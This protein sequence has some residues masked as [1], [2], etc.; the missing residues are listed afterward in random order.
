MRTLNENDR[1][2]ITDSGLFDAVWYSKRFADVA[3]VGLDPLEHYF[4]IGIYAGRDPGPLF[5]GKHYL[6][7]LNGRRHADVPVLDYLRQ[8]WQEQI[9]P[10]P[11]FDVGFYLDRNEDIRAA[12]LDPLRH[13]RYAGGLEGRQPHP[14]FPTWRVLERCP[15]LREAHRNPLEYYLSGDWTEDPCPE[16]TAYLALQESR[17]GPRL[18]TSRAPQPTPAHIPREKLPSAGLVSTDL[19]AIAIYLPQFHAIPENDEWWGK[20]FTEWTNVRRA[21]PQYEGHHQPHVPH[22]NLGYYDLHDASVLEKQAAMARAA[23]IE[24]FCFYY[25]W[26]NGRRLLN[27]PTDRLLATGK[28]DFPFCFCWANENWTRT[29]DGGDKEILIGQEHSYE[30]DERF[31]LDLLPAFRDPRY[32]RVDGKPLLIVYRPGLL[33][34][35]AATARH[36]RE[37]C[38][39]EGLGEIFLARMQMFDWEL[40]GRDPGYD[41][42]IQFAPVSRGHSPNLKDTVRLHDPAKFTGEV[43][44]YRLSAANYAFEPIGPQLWPGVCPSWDNTAR[45]MERGHSWVNSTPETYHWWLSTVAHRARQA[46]PAQQRFVFINAWNEWAEGCHLEPD[47]KFGYAWLNATR[48]ALTDA[49]L[50]AAP[51]RRRVLVVGHDAARAGAQMVLLALLREWKE[52]LDIECRLVL[53]GDGVL[54]PEFEKTCPTLVL[55]DQPDEASRRQALA[56]FLQPAPEVIL[57]NTVVIGPFL[58]ELKSTGAPIVSY[59][60]ELQKSIERWAPGAIMAATVADSDHFIAVSPPVAENL[61]RNHGIAPADISC[62]HPY[63]K[64][65]HF[66][67]PARMEE[68]RTELGLQP[69]DKVVFACG[70]MDWRKGPDL[71]AEIALKVLGAVPEARIVWIGADT[72]DEAGSRAKA[73][74]TDPRIRFL[75]EQ[76]T[77]RDYLALGSAFLLSSREDPFP[78]VTLEA[79]DAGLP[80]VCFAGAGGMPDFVGNSCGRTVPFEDVEA[81]ARALIEILSNDPLRESLGHT[82]RESVR[83]KHDAAKGS[84]AVLSVLKRL[85]DGESPVPP[86]S[87]RP[88]V[89]VIVPNYNH[90]RFLTERL[91]SITR[92]TLSDLEIILLDDCS[93]DNSLE[94]LREFV[95]REPRARLIPNS[96]NSGSTFKQW[97]K[98]FAEARGKYIWIAES[99]DSAEPELLATLVGKLEANPAAVLAACCPCSIEGDVNHGPPRQWYNELF[100]TKWESDYR[101]DGLQEIREVLSRK[102]SIL[103]AS[104]VVFRNLPGLSGLVEPDMRL[105]AD[106]LFWVRLLRNGDFEYSHRMLNKWRINSSNAR[107]RPP[108]D[109]EWR[110]GRRVLEDIANIL[111]LDSVGRANL[112]HSFS[113]ECQSWLANHLEADAPFARPK[114]TAPRVTAIVPNFNYATFLP[115]RLESILGQTRRDLE[116]LVLD[117]ASTDISLEVIESYRRRFPDL[118]RVLPNTTNSGSP[119]PQ[120]LRGIREAKGD[121][122]WIAE[123]DDSCEPDFLESLL[124]FFEDSSVGIAYSQS[125]GL[126]EHGRVTRTEFLEHTEHLHPDRWKADYT[127][128]GIREAMDWM[129]CRN[130]I[131]NASAALIRREALTTLG[132]DL[133]AYRSCGDWFLYLSILRHWNVGYCARSLNKFRRHGRAVTRTTNQSEAYLREVAS[134]RS[135]VSQVFPLHRSQIPRLDHF[136]D[137]DYVFEG[138]AKPSQHH[139]TRPILE[140]AERKTRDRLRLA[141]ISTNISAHSGG[142]EILWQ[143]AALEARRRGHDVIAVTKAWR[144][145]PP[146][147]A[148]FAQAGIKHLETE[149]GGHDAVISFRPDLAIIST[150]NENEGWLEF[151]KFLPAGIPYVVVNQ[152]VKEEAYSPLPDYND[153]L[154]EGMAAAK[155]VFFVSKNNHQIME[156]RLGIPIP[157]GDLAYNPLDIPPGEPIPMPDFTDGLQIAFPANILFIHKGHD[158]LLQVMSKEKW[159]QR[160]ITINLYGKGEDEGKVRE[161]L[162]QAG[163]QNVNLRGHIAPAEIWKKNHA[164]LLASRME[165]QSLALIGAM[166]AGR[167]P[168]VTAVGGSAEVIRNNETGFLAAQPTPEHLDE[169]MERAWQRRHEWPQIGLAARESAL[170]LVPKDPVGDFVDRLQSLLESKHSTPKEV[171]IKIPQGLVKHSHGFCPICEK[172]VTFS[173]KNEWLRDHYLCSGCGSIPRERAIMHVIQQNYPNWRELRI[174]ESSPGSRG[175]SVKLREQCKH[176][177]ASQY[178][179]ELGFGNTHSGHGYRSEDLEKQTFPNESFDIVVTQDV[180]EHIF[181]AEAAFRDIHRT[182]KPGGAH[183]FTTPLINKTKQTQQWAKRLPD[184]TIVHLHPAE[185]HGNPMSSEGSL[186]TWHWGFDILDHIQRANAGAAEMIFTENPAMGIEAEYLEVIVQKKPNAYE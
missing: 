135:F 115:E 37:T 162:A 58:K 154:R 31:I 45:R 55:T 131:I 24:G 27:M 174:H 176:Y 101:A 107:T 7:Q 134:I 50:P 185:Y 146:F 114:G 125:L 172:N 23:G 128:L 11:L 150:S 104:G 19:R 119:Y 86:L 25:Y 160:A 159:R 41:S 26:F 140:E 143:K 54:R 47:E 139:P 83:A 32:I 108:G 62:L 98:G 157:H 106:W 116:I 166:V 66:V 29:W 123:A 145:L 161:I 9:N 1:K 18:P 155:R 179:P 93:T 2:L 147:S 149:H 182:L 181:D 17:S 72:G 170:N 158:I 164:V 56:K 71:F 87:G 184:G 129:A 103:N 122:V 144:P 68:L 36:W 4:R 6:E 61:V 69:G 57:A 12:G 8:G 76:E 124:P 133:L 165:G 80:A 64:T 59:V 99:D 118:I 77:P 70:T 171:S 126:D 117:D 30:C 137:R 22:P 89:S 38:R 34:D 142:S 63:I 84:E 3:K 90:A 35:P 178:D 173:A 156:R 102:N 53:L 148:E 20:G 94:I 81:A 136:L 49:A 67:P 132:E 163:I 73:L 169:A 112:L 79:A 95:D 14:S 46:L 110:E 120:W 85:A 39:R 75:G 111:R 52:R 186:V 175:A 127:E 96:E 13:F 100:G 44:D 78:L 65:S 109:L 88:L 15:H 177:F 5:S 33:P 121:L 82:A 74:A 16:A 168:I 10:H 92:Q 152:L 183:I 51:P 180:M 43:R 167:V 91:E 60:H 130:T 153:L 105:C 113:R 42:V 141:F 151:Q 97:R 28:P 138:I 40:E 21:T 48:L